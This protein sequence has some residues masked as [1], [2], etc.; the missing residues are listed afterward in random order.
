MT[1]LFPVV[2]EIFKMRLLHSD[3]LRT[4]IN[5]LGDAFGA[6]IVAHLCREELARTPPPDDDIE[7]S[8]CFTVLLNILE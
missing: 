3:R 1:C 5:V 2:S 4:S 7:G 6:G 8:K